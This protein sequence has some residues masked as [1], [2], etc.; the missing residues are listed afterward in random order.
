MAVYMAKRLISGNLIDFISLDDHV[1]VRR[2]MWMGPWW[3]GPFRSW[4]CGV[5]MESTSSPSNG[6]TRPMWSSRRITGFQA[7]DIVTVIGKADKIDRFEQD[8]QP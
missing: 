5:P 2:I 7:D 1:E 4:M 8:V 6:D 3:A